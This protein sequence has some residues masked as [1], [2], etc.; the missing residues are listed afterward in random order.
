MSAVGL[1]AAAQAASG[2]QLQVTAMT[3]NLFQGPELTEASS[4]TSL[5]EFLAAAA[6]DYGEVQRTDFPQERERSLR[7]RNR[8][9]PI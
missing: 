2:N 7:K 8:P 6:Q 5:T 3:Y 1:P 9:R 4:A